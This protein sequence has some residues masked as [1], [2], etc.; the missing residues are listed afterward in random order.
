[1]PDKL[2]SRPTP[3]VVVDL[4]VLDAN[5]A[6][7]AARAAEGGMALRPHVKTHKCLEI[8]RRQVAAG[9][10]GITVATVAEAEV[11]V[12]AG[13]EDIFIAYPLW[14]DAA[15]GA[16][17]RKLAEVATLRVGVD[18]VEGVEALARNAGLRVAR[19]L[20]EIDSGHHRTGV[21]ASQAGEVARAAA[22]TG[23]EVEGV[24]TF[25]GHSYLPGQAEHAATDES[26][27]LAGA[28]AALHEAGISA[29]VISGGSTPSAAGTDGE[30]LTEMR[31]G[32]Y[33]FNDAQ[34]VELATCSPGDVALTAYATVVSRSAD[35]AVVDAGG[36]VLAADRPGWATGFGRLPD[37][38]D[39][40]VIALSEHHATIKFPTDEDPPRLGETVRVMPNHVCAAVNLVD[41]LVVM[42]HGAVIDTWRVAARGANT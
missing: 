11:F 18:S 38:L 2:S 1:V 41:E 40:R 27:A 34:Q 21:P 24:F 22:A 36:K 17:L 19:V 32:V 35:R 39:A 29:D 28:A 5:I 7:M 13:F 12:A 42:Q 33:V 10:S 14:V 37:H 25:P 6:R 3:Y 30:V 4:D 20:V 31:P 26:T 8:A 16:R 23:L 15:K 9:A